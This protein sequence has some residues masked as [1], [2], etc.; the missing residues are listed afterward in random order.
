MESKA[1]TWTINKKK[2]KRQYIIP[3]INMHTIV[4]MMMMDLIML[5]LLKLMMLNA[6]L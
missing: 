5:V 1:D 6:M 4:R 3:N 2:A